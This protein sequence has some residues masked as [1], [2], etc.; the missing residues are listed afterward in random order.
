MTFEQVH[1]IGARRHK[2]RWLHANRRAVEAASAA[3]MSYSKPSEKYAIALIV[4]KI[5][6]GQMI[7]TGFAWSEEAG[8]WIPR[9]C[10][11]VAKRLAGKAAEG[12]I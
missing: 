9:K 12:I 1:E 2:D 6:D 5:L 10:V 8:K 11:Q 4:L 3:G 7:D